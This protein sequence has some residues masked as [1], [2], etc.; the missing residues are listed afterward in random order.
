[1]T[2]VVTHN[3]TSTT[4]ESTSSGTGGGLGIVGPSEWNAN[5]T[6]TGLAT[7]AQGGTGISS[8][9]GVTYFSSATKIADSGTLTQNAVMLGGGANGA[10]TVVGTVG[11]TSQVLFGGTAGGAP[12]WGTAPGG[13]GSPGGA[14]GSIQ[15]STSSSFGGFG[16]FNTS[17]KTVQVGSSSTSASAWS[18]QVYNITDSVSAPANYERMGIAWS[19]NAATIGTT[20]AGGSGT[21][22]NVSF[23]G[24]QPTLTGVTTSGDLCAFTAYD[25]FGSLQ[26]VRWQNSNLTDASNRWQLSPTGYTLN[27]TGNGAILVNPDSNIWKAGGNATQSGPGFFQMATGTSTTLPASP[28]VGT[29]GVITD[30]SS[31][32]TFGSTPAGGG[33][34]K[35]LIWYNGSHWAVIGI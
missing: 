26:T 12:Q 14:D 34:G 15:Y 21:L 17:S 13:G 11:T 33:S 8:G 19:G 18:L 30:G 32:A 7:P 5:H 28:V 4:T 20:G 3:F 35:N 9:L 31:S 10:P 16:F 25:V 1:M 27:G 22:R 29:I 6:L 24:A 23:S 2:L